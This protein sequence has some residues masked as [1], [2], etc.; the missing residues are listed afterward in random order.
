MQNRTA[1]FLVTITLPLAIGFPPNLA[2]DPPSWAP[3]YGYRDKDD[4]ERYKDEMEYRRERRKD[5]MEYRRERYKDEKERRKEEWKYR[6]K[7]Y[8]YDDDD[9]EKEWKRRRHESRDWRRDRDDR[10]RRPAPPPDYGI[11]RG[12]CNREQLGAVIGGTIGGAI[13]SRVGK[14]DG[15]TLA[16]IAGAVIGLMVGKS[17]GRQMDEVDQHCIGQTLEKAKRL[18][19][20]AWKNPDTNTQHEVT[21]LNSYQQNGYPC[22]DYIAKSEINGVWEKEY[23]SA[24]RRSDGTWEPVE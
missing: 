7:R 20:V 6:K 4:R 15:K 9:D 11:T 8:K 24:C 3:A 1:S 19:V 17:I 2:A 22:R 5:E 12:T 10:Y 13:G 23:R 14:G 18:E 16:T 21:P